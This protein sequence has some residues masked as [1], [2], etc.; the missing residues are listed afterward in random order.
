M[1]TQQQNKT[2]G[3]GN[4]QANIPAQELEAQGIGVGRGLRG[5]R[6]QGEPRSRGGPGTE[7]LELDRTRKHRPVRT[8]PPLGG[9]ARI[10]RKFLRRH[11][12]HTHLFIDCIRTPGQRVGRTVAQR[13]RAASAR[14]PPGCGRRPA[15]P[16]RRAAAPDRA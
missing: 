14:P 8:A 10:S 2:Q 4:V 13:I 16:H 15:P 12:H 1:A 3:K 7:Q 6:R 5:L 9:A 11:S